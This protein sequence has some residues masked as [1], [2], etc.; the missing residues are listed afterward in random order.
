M[1]KETVRTIYLKKETME[2][3]EKAAAEDSRS[4]SGFLAMLLKKY[5]KKTKKEEGG[6]DS[7]TDN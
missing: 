7:K 1:K 2:E 4:V 5:F 3:L 6:N